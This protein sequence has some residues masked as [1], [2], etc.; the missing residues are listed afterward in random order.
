MQVKLL[1]THYKNIA[2]ITGILSLLILIFNMFYQELFESNNLFF[3][4]IFKN[5]F[6]I[7]LLVFSFTQE[8]IET[9]E[10]S[11]LRFERLKQAVI[12]GGVILVF[13]SISE[14]I[15]Y[16]GH[17]DMKSGYEIMVMVLLFYLITFHS[18]KT[19]LTSK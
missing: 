5:I 8:K 3:K 18:Y 1:P 15:F 6:L 11:L 10:I 19:K 7:S 2:F 16:H 12:F 9:D 17:I 4:W 13:D 14:L